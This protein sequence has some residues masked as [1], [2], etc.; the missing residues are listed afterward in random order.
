MSK[1]TKNLRKFRSTRFLRVNSTGGRL[2]IAL[3]PRYIRRP[4]TEDSDFVSLLMFNS[5]L[6]FARRGDVGP[7]RLWLGC[8]AG[9][10]WERE[11]MRSRGY[12]SGGPLGGE[13][14]GVRVE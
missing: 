7:G 5:E 4:V 11:N 10:V 8:A 6:D 3:L 13:G 1:N 12:V 14:V 2:L 9:T